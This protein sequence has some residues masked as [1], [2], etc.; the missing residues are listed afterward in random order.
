MMGGW[1][2]TTWVPAWG[3]KAHSVADAETGRKQK[4][5]Q[6]F[7]LHPKAQPLKWTFP[8]PIVSQW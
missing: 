3:S 2:P 7:L 4:G 8:S 5:V 6:P 1:V